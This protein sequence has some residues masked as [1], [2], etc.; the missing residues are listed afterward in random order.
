MVLLHTVNFTV[1]T[2]LQ[3][4]LEIDTFET[5]NVYAMGTRPMV[6]ASETSIFSF[7]SIY[8]VLFLLLLLVVL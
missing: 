3:V 4:Y 7:S 8:G 2:A 1:F 5:E 6:L